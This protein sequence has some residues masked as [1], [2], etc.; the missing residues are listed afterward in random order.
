MPCGSE[1]SDDEEMQRTDSPAPVTPLKLLPNEGAGHD[2]LDAESSECESDNDECE[3]ED[4]VPPKKR[5]RVVAEYVLV[6]DGLLASE[7]CSPKR[8]MN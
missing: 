6:N 8:I 1:S 4:P 3:D 5:K 2:I 7:L